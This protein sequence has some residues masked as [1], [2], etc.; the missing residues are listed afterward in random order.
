MIKDYL[1]FALRSISRRKLRAWLTMIGIFIGIAS[2]VSLVP[3]GQGLE[4]VN[5]QFAQL[6]TNK[7]IIAGGAFGPP[8][9][10]LS[11]LTDHDIRV[12]E[13]VKGVD[14]IGRM[15]ES[16]TIVTFNKKAESVPTH[17]LP[18]SGEERELM[19]EADDIEV[20]S[21]RA[22]KNND[23]KSAMIGY[24]LAHDDKI[25]GKVVK[26]G[27]TIKIQGSEFKVVGIVHK[28]GTPLEDKLVYIT[29]EEGF[30]LRDAKDKFD[31]LFVK[32]TEGISPDIVAENIKKALR[33]DRGLKEGEEDFE[34]QT[35]ENIVNVFGDILTIVQIILAGIIA[36][37]VVV[38]AI[39]IMNS[40]YTSVLERTRDIGVMKAI[41][42]K[43]V[44]I[45]LIFL[46]EYSLLGLAGG[47][48]GVIIGVTL[49]KSIEF[50]ATNIFQTTLVKAIFPPELLIGALLF[51]LV[52]GTVSGILPA[53]QAARLNPVDALRYE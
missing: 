50:A 42:A 30:E 43:R 3:L 17:A 44:D 47:L 48:I 16:F 5:S 15:L 19:F 45:L 49:S 27:N 13:K 18:T 10:S 1:L 40:M 32:T 11:K 20:I 51:S 6:G 7:V 46:F 14:T 35:L 2:M 24:S 38:G 41:G 25:F 33:R 29:L 37:S 26:V 21:G 31:F 8:G 28:K 4:E 39:G 23:G 53:L 12:V 9:S 36:I 52:I 34:V 22:L